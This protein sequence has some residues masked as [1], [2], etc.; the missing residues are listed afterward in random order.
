H[1]LILPVSS[2][3]AAALI[4]HPE[5][6]SRVHVLFN[7][8]SVPAED[9]GDTGKL[10]ELLRS[11][12]EVRRWLL[13]VGKLS[14]RK[15][16]AAAVQVLR[17]LMD[18]GE[19][20]TGLLLA[21]DV[22]PDYQPVMEQ[23]IA[24]AGVGNRVAMIGNFDG[25]ASLLQRADTLLLPSFR[26]GLPRSLVEAVTAGKPAFSFPC[27]GVED[28]YGPHR[29]TFVSADSTAAALVSTVRQAWSQ[30]EAS[31]KAFAEVRESVL[32]RFSPQAHLARLSGLL[33]G[34]SRKPF[35]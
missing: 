31:A 18:A 14:P 4:P 33:N 8:V 35:R 1:D 2:T 5:F 34:P 9:P 22:D 28:I 23:A 17:S 24:A 21:G 29:S 27:E 16:Q 11:Y 19:T 26:E 7:S 6:T 3:I 32:A 25:V 30:P 20:D 15:N 10:D 13:V 12:P